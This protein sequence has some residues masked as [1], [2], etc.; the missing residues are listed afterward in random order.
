[1]TSA[2]EAQQRRRTHVKEVKTELE[3]GMAKMW[4]FIDCSMQN[5]R[6]VRTAPTH[7]A[8]RA[9]KTVDRPPNQPAREH[10]GIV[11]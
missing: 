3:N 2:I 6:K 5:A 8:G 1:M 7:A 9:L 11:C 10:D 4:L